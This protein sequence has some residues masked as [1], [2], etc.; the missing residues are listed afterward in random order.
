MRS[1]FEPGKI[2]DTIL[3]LDAHGWRTSKTTSSFVILGEKIALIE[4]A[5]KSSAEKIL[6]GLRNYN[7]DL[8]KIFYILVSHRHFD[9]AAG[10]PPLLKH[11]PNAVIGAHLYAI[12]NYKNPEK[13]NIA[14]RQ[15]YGEYAEPID[16]VREEEKLHVLKDGEI[17]ELGN[18]LEIEVVYTPGH[19]S[20]HY[21]YYERKNKFMFTGDA[22][23]I[24][25]YRSLSTIP[26]TF[27]PSFKYENYI[28]SLEKMLNYD[29]EI[30]SFAHFGGVIGKDANEIIRKTIETLEDW[31]NIAEEVWE[32][33]RNVSDIAKRLKEKYQEKLEVFPIQVREFVF[34][35]LATGLA[36]SLFKRK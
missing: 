15:I 31:K 14:A 10:A 32:T 21:A 4:P 29:L 23:G 36:N 13:I 28:K 17:I 6:E 24:F 1:F 9:H 22:V 11:L 2:T 3:M 35:I 26:T 34:Q 30:V 5:H 12:E 18:E 25:G 20:D 16:P 33:S 27:P 19:T 8:N 7:I